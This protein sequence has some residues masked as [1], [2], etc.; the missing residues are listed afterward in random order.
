MEAFQAVRVKDVFLPDIRLKRPDAQIHCHNER[1]FR[2]IRQR[3]EN[4]SGRG[5]EIKEWEDN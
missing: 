3:T 4:S 5:A 1:L 2:I